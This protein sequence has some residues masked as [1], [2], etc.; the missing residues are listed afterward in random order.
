M[1]HKRLK[2]G[3]EFLLTLSILF[4]LQAAL[5]W[6]LTANLNETAFGLSA[7]QIQSP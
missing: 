2:I 4:G 5:M 3:P 7:A 1:V 6:L